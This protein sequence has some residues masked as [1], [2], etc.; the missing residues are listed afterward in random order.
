[1][2]AFAHAKINW[3]LD[4]TGVN[5]AFHVLDMIMDSVSLCD[6]LEFEKTEDGVITVGEIGD[7]ANMEDNLVWRAA[8]ALQKHT[9]TP[10]G[11]KISMVKRIPSG[12]GMA[13]GSADCAATLRALNA[14]W[15]VHVPDDQMAEIALSLGSDV[16]YCYFAG[17]KRAK[18]RGEILSPC[19]GE[20]KY[21]LVLAMG[22]GHLPTGPV[23]KKC[24]ELGIENH[25]NN[26]VIAEALN[27]GDFETLIRLLPDANVMQPA[28]QQLCPD[29][30][31]TLAVLRSVGAKA[32]F[33]TGSGAACVGLFETEEDAKAAD[34]ALAGKVFW[35]TYAHT[36]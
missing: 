34:D 32:A 21:H 31:E 1:M 2:K 4:I 27:A 25:P 35:H 15:Q 17:R 11:V 18:G 3:T 8:D 30:A 24:D 14:L 12:A 33:M 36:V 13:G 23:F 26:D 5:G 29:V 19:G 20:K 28:A 10:F 6:D 7:V 16:P 22:E 9:G